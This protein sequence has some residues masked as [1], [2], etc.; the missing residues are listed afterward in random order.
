[1]RGQM[2][3]KSRIFQ[4]HNVGV[5]NTF[6]P[7]RLTSLFLVTGGHGEVLAAR[8]PQVHWERKRDI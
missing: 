3:V 8:Q 6:Y 1:M 2:Q 7:H 5:A 4:V